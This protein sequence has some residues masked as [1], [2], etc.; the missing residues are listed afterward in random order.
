[1]QQGQETHFQED[2]AYDR[3]TWK[4]GQMGD[5]VS[6]YDVETLEELRRQFRVC[7][8]HTFDTFIDYLTEGQAEDVEE[9]VSGQMVKRHFKRRHLAKRHFNF[10]VFWD[11]PAQRLL[12]Q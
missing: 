7:N 11:T 2:Q 4:A 8:D 9:Q 10:L 5:A 3:F 12:K 6:K 1:M